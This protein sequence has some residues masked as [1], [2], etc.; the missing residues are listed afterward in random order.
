MTT[1]PT[2]KVY[3]LL[4]G[5]DDYPSPIPKLN[6]C[7][8]DVHRIQSYLQAEVEDDALQLRMLK[9]QDATYD[10]II[11]AFREH[12]GQAGPQDIVWFHFSGH[13]MEDF[14]AREFKESLEPNGKDQN[15]VCYQED[16]EK[17]SFLLADKELAVL[18][19]E[20]AHE[21]KEKAPH[22][23]VSLDC[24]HS[25]SGTRD[26]EWESSNTIKERVV[27]LRKI[28]RWEDAASAGKTRALSTYLNGYFKADQL[29]VPLSEHILFSACSSIQ[30]AGDTAEG[31]LFTTGLIET[32]SAAKEPL[33]YADLFIRTRAAVQAV[34]KDQ[35]PQFETIGGFDPHRQFLDG[36]SLGIPDQYEL[37][38]E[39]GHWMI[40]CGAIH[41]IPVQ[42]KEPIKV[43]VLTAASDVLV[44]GTITSVGA[45]KS[46]L[47][48]EDESRLTT[49]VFYQARIKFLPLPALH[50]LLKGKK[51]ALA[52]IIEEWDES[53]GIKWTNSEEIP[54]DLSVEVKGAGYHV[55]DHRNS[56]QLFVQEQSEKA[57]RQLIA[58]LGKVVR[59]ERTLALANPKSQ[60]REHL[61]LEL[62][63][64][65][66]QHQ[67]VKFVD[68]HVHIFASTTDLIKHENMLLAGLLPQLRIKD[69]SRQL[70]FYLFHMRKDFSIQ[71]YEGELVFRPFEH[72]GK[73]EVVL[74]LLKAHKG[75]GLGP[76]DKET[77]SYFKLFATTEALDYQQLLQTG[78]TDHSRDADWAWS[79]VAVSDD[80]CTIDLKIQLT[81]DS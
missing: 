26:S 71:S 41:G 44:S 40:K 28:K 63:V 49:G 79:P 52:G 81:N 18:L 34:H 12:L 75:W 58:N 64:L 54:A 65:I 55:Y 19:Y 1:L 31:G 48:L 11:T 37:I 61:E 16:I 43:E 20:L 24:C 70:H 38:H 72:P 50:V 42:P 47:L 57:D 76:G 15:L 25:G 5:I 8:K 36:R 46:Q 3:S 30:T 73:Q 53:K 2:P 68:K 23:I 74:P 80:W 22:I 69:T 66:N 51:E 60:I 7:L 29:S 45:Q 32:L 59:W 78:I 39:A 56:Q 13:G 62:E 14:T 9:N 33:S 10:N 6:G 35:S 21:N 77:Y 67:K 4:V 27:S 17:G